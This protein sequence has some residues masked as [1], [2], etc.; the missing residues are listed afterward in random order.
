LQVQKLIALFK[1]ANVPQSVPNNRLDERRRY[2]ERSQTYHYEER[3]PSFPIEELRQAR[4]DEQRR[5][6]GHFLVED[7][8]RAPHFAP[9]GV[10]SRFV[11]SL[12]TAQ[13]DHHIYYQPAHLAHEPRH[14]PLAL[15]SQHVPLV[16]ER[17]HVHSVPELRHVPSAYYHTLAPPDDSY[18][19]PA[20][21]LGPVR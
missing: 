15:D 2:K 9:S 19:R 5:T 6:A 1:P 14:V 4:F 12:A 21:D 13:D 18:Y 16:L 8:Y 17:Q 3:Q 20:V 11:C 10:E 7:P